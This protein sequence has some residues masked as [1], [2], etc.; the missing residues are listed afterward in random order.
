MAMQLFFLLTVAVGKTEL[1]ITVTWNEHQGTS[2]HWWLDWL[3]NCLF[4][5]TT[6]K[7]WK[8]SITGPLGG[9]S[10]SGFPSQRASYAERFSMLWHLHVANNQWS[11][12]MRHWSDMQSTSIWGS[13]LSGWK[14]WQQAIFTHPWNNSKGERSAP[15][16]NIIAVPDII[17]N[18]GCNMIVLHWVI[19]MLENL[20]FAPCH[21]DFRELAFCTKPSWCWKIWVLHWAIMMFEEFYFCLRKVQLCIHIFKLTSF[22]QTTLS[23]VPMLCSTHWAIFTILFL[24]P[25]HFLH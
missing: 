24:N 13:L 25:L 14:S 12:L 20:S 3:F 18:A 19:M 1:I 5:P 8:L 21:H 23:P 9:E 7:K 4:R 17:L 10:T 6:K 16:D 11:T 22:F 15:C 2:T